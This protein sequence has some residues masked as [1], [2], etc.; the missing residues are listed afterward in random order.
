MA[1]TNMMMANCWAISDPPGCGACTSSC[2]HSRD[3]RMT[4]HDRHV[5]R[6]GRSSERRCM[7][8][9]DKVI[10]PRG[11]KDQSEHN[12]LNDSDNFHRPSSN[13]EKWGLR[14]EVP[15]VT[16]VVSNSAKRED[17][18]RLTGCAPISFHLRKGNY[19]RGYLQSGW[20][21]RFQDALDCFKEG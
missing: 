12:S 20:D 2:K 1:C 7:T 4:L 18:S 6:C 8:G 13:R 19:L 15:L 16:A 21:G 14:P 3:Q 9:V 11:K 17:H 5:F 10:D